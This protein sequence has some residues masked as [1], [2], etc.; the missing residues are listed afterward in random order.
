MFKHTKLSI[1]IGISLYFVPFLNISQNVY[2]DTELAK[3][4]TQLGLSVGDG[5]YKSLKA[6]KDVDTKLELADLNSAHEQLVKTY[7]TEVLKNRNAIEMETAVVDASFNTIEATAVIA[8]AY[9]LP[10]VVVTAPVVVTTSVMKYA[11]KKAME[12]LAEEEKQKSLLFFGVGLKNLST[13]DRKNFDKLVKNNDANGAKE[14]FE[15]KVESFG[16]IKK[17]L[18]DDPEAVTLFDATMNDSFTSAGVSAALVLVDKNKKSIGKVEEDLTKHIKETSKQFKKYSADVYELKKNS[19]QLVQKIKENTED[20]KNMA[21]K[22][23]TNKKELAAIGQVL[24]DQSPPETQLKLL[25][26]EN[27]MPELSQETREILKEKVQIEVKKKDLIKKTTKVATTIRDVNTIF[28]NLGIRDKNLDSAVKISTHGQMT[29]SKLLS[30]PPDYVGALAAFTGLFGEG[31]VDPTFEKMNK[32]L[33]DIITLQKETLV[34][35]KE[36]SSQLE[37]MEKAILLELFD[38]KYDILMMHDATRTTYWNSYAVCQ[39]AIVNLENEESNFNFSENSLRFTSSNSLLNYT[40]SYKSNIYNCA[41]LLTDTFS[42]FQNEETFGNKFNLFFSFQ[43]FYE[44]NNIEIGSRLKD[45]Q[46]NTFK[47]SYNMIRQVWN[48]EEFGSFSSTFAF[49]SSPANNVDTLKKR[50]IFL[51]RKNKKN[52][53]LTCKNSI[54]TERHKAL[55]CNNTQTEF[56]SNKTLIEEKAEYK[57]EFYLSNMIFREEVSEV[58]KWASVVASP[59]NFVAEGV[60]ISSSPLDWEGLAKIKREPPGKRIIRG[61]Q[62]LADV[63]IAQQ[64]MIYGDLT[65]YFIYELIWDKNKKNFISSIDIAEMEK[66]DKAKW[67]LIQN[68][69]KLLKNNAN[70]WLQR[71]VAMIILNE[72]ARKDSKGNPMNSFMYDNA[73]SIFYNNPSDN[74]EYPNMT[75]TSKQSAKD[76]LLHLFDF[77]PEVEFFEKDSETS[78]DGSPM[79]IPRKVMMKLGE[80]E[81]EMP[82]PKL[83]EK[84]SFDYPSSLKSRIHERDLLAE[85]WA[86]YTI[87]ERMG[88]SAKPIIKVLAGGE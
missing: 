27:F 70:P 49:L 21:N 1:S 31:Q 2:A 61:A 55:L 37:K 77:S 23:D 9:A 45:F 56:N 43:K 13:Q 4:I 38:I 83:W 14:F 75:A 62:W 22:T 40:I 60:E 88:D 19:E 81:L 24:L 78:L 67:A 32:R 86:D 12:S 53:I 29:I 68:A 69:L 82:D 16:K 63:S 74:S 66:T 3:S 25:E 17:A 11:N 28:N 47:P 58:I 34:A 80:I 8:T 36:L 71:N 54:L 57:S 76:L 65:A 73:I 48:K 85:R 59:Y 26:N 7:Q 10:S 18:S 6:E 35:I 87:F 79:S 50:L 46:D 64:T 44:S 84:R 30:V 51:S 5:I 41:K 15:K 42:G 72:S 52:K 39:T 20:I 33:D